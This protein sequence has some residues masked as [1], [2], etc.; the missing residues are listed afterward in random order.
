LNLR[1]LSNNIC[2]C[3]FERA[4]DVM[5]KYEARSKGTTMNMDKQFRVENF[6]DFS[7]LLTQKLL[8]NFNNRQI[9]NDIHICL[10][11]TIVL[12]FSEA[13]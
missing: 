11:Q 8:N 7:L 6:W 13:L 3:G 2:E 1:I 5:A 10:S 12:S 4:G 9:C